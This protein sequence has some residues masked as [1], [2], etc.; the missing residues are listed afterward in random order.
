MEEIKVAIIDKKSNL[1]T[2]L[3]KNS[4]NV[5]FSGMN[6]GLDIGYAITK[7][8]RVY[9]FGADADDRHR[10]F[11]EVMP[12]GIDLGIVVVDSKKN[13]SKDDKKVIKDVKSKKMPCMVFCSETGEGE[14]HS[15]AISSVRI[16]GYKL[17]DFI[18]QMS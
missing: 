10:F 12:A 5:E 7:Q 18:K 8:K 9:A 3:I 14:F 1:I 11:E 15:P 6:S 13:I 4:V 17:L 16:P 2:N